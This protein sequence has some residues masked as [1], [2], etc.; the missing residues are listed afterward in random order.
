MTL[1]TTEMCMTWLTQLSL[2]NRTLVG[3]ASLLVGV[4][5]VISMTSLKQEL[6][7]S[8]QIPIATVIGQFPGASPTVVEQ[9]VT[10]AVEA[11]AQEVPGVTSTQSTS[12]GGVSVV[13]VEMEYGTDLAAVQRDLQQAV[14][15]LTGLPPGVEPVV[16]TGSTDDFPVVQLAA[17]SSV[18]EAALAQILREQV[19]PLLEGIDGVS[20]VTISGVGERMISIDLDEAA[21]A[22]RGISPFEVSNVLQANGVR[23][24][25]GTV[26][27]GER[28]L[29]VQVGAPITTL[30]ELRNLYLPSTLP[31]G[32][33]IRLGEV[34]QVTS[35]F[36]P[37]TGY[38]RTG[39]K[40]SIGIGVTKTADSNTVA[41]SHAV[42][43]LLPQ[44]EDRLGRG[45]AVTVVFDQAPYI[46]QSIDDLTTE[47]LLGLFFAVLVILLFL[48]S[49][50]ATLVTAVS[51]PL[52]LLV[53]LIVI[54]LSG[55]SL[56]IL[57]LAALTIAVGRVV[58]DSIV[59]I[60][61]IKRHLGDGEPMR[62]AVPGAV[63]EVASAITA[64]T[65]TTVAVFLP[66]ALVGGQV[67]E[68]F[69]PFAIT[70]AAALLGSLIVSLTIVPVLASWFLKPGAPPTGE[71]PPAVE[72][73]PPLQRGYLPI[74]RT[75]LARPLLTCLVAV[76]V[77]A[78]TFALIPMLKTN[79]LNDSG[80]N[81][82]QISQELPPGTGLATTDAAARRVEQVLADTPGVQSYQT[83]VGSPGDSPYALGG[84]GITSNTASFF[85]TTDIEGGA[86]DQAAL[87]DG[88]RS[89]LN[90]LPDAGTVT[91]QSGGGPGAG[92]LEVVVRAENDQALT[93][94][95]T[96]VEQ[97]MRA[98]PGAVDVVNNL[99]AQQPAI[100]I[101]VDRRAAAIA[102]LS[103]Q[104]IG[105]A[106]A[107]AL[108]GA[109]VGVLAIDGAPQ[110]V[111]LRTGAAPSD[112]AA[113]QALPLG[114]LVRLGHVADVREVLQPASITRIDGARSAS[115]TATPDAD[116]LGAVTADL[117]QRLDALTLPAGASAEIGGVSAEQDEAFG[118]LGL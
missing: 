55:Y 57:T 98:V 93:S 34:A 21:L 17:T 7:P 90:S 31:G 44:I 73:R 88:L 116:D 25:A 99:A 39:G 97:A 69:R 45:G 78:A 40:P 8:L 94:A 14:S 9:Q 46:E 96:A 84:E 51:I 16:V 2:R 49:L 64:S 77:L 33:L 113:L 29:S 85:V 67:G 35:Q 106:V 101:A 103:D 79:F 58:D 81:T 53:A 24:P 13:N 5:G 109:P 32:G 28:Q 108:R 38:S 92:R 76:L 114:R 10:A 74:L 6:I 59:V 65:L 71:Q 1:P 23:V 70:V 20:G 3:L 107:A 105:Q 61:N 42:R 43:D 91:V 111:V 30:D 18:P 80:Q 11:A 19:V 62:Q 4:F 82:F 37:A 66:I 50:R 86:A 104:Q 115:I 12:S 48:L 83:Q 41:V 102:G 118:Q 15:G 36:E 47:G 112:V 95:A 27:S 56:N 89:R 54:Y 22:Q 52:S 75:A 87:Q 72:R 63:R 26:G 100:E 110:N 117:T 68:L 60:E